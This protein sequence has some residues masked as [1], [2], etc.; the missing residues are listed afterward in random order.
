MPPAASGPSPSPISLYD[1]AVSRRAK[2][3]PALASRPIPTRLVPPS[4]TP[5]AMLA[6]PM[7]A[8]N[9]DAIID[10]GTPTIGWIGPALLGI[11]IAAFGWA[12]RVFEWLS[13]LA[14]KPPTTAPATAAPSA[15]VTPSPQPTPP[16]PS[17]TPL[18]PWGNGLQVISRSNAANLKQIAQLQGVFGTDGIQWAWPSDCSPLLP[19]Q[20][21][22]GEKLARQVEAW[23][24]Y[25]L[26][27]IRP[28]VEISVTH[29]PVRNLN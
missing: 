27:T 7:G 16:P 3:C 13:T 17:P 25:D 8:S 22:P 12:G 23:A 19:V 29:A 10:E 6:T 11:L 4:P 28:T 2:S 20:T 5:R 18:V 26:G 14:T 24:L 1:P 21:W 15:A 9:L